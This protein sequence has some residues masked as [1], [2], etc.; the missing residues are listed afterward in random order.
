MRINPVNFNQTQ[1]NRQVSFGMS[2][3]HIND[4]VKDLIK[5]DTEAG[6]ILEMAKQL[7]QDGKNLS[8]FIGKVFTTDYLSAN[9]FRDDK[10]PL[11]I[12]E[13]PLVTIHND[14]NLS[15]ENTNVAKLISNLVKKF[16]LPETQQQIKV[17]QARRVVINK[18][19][20]CLDQIEN[21][22]PTPEP[23][24]GQ[25]FLSAFKDLLRAYGYLPSKK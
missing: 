6:E 21:K 22:V 5:T 2:K 15:L 25:G 24:T 10:K 3:L 7:A 1:Q 23:K 13:D 4:K 19:S 17:E 18:L 9:I 14:A 20:K 12:I 11:S 16:N 8:V